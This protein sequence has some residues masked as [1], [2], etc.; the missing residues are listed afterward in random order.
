MLTGNLFVYDFESMKNIRLVDDKQPAFDPEETDPA[1]LDKAYKVSVIAG[2][3]MFVCLII[4]WP[5][6][7]HTSHYVFSEKFYTFWVVIAVTWGFVAALIIIVMPIA[8]SAP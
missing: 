1:V 2:L 5:I 8:E 7:M 6:P 4:L 3:I